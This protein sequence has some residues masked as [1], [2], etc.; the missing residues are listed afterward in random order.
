[1]VHKKQ[2]T[3]VLR[4]S[5]IIVTII[6]LV[7]IAV[8]VISL[9]RKD[10]DAFA[11][12]LAEKGLVMAGT[13]WCHYCA[14][15]KD[16]FKGAFEDVLIPTGAYKDCDQQKTWCEEA[17]VEGYPSWVLP[18]GNLLV[19]VQRLTTLATVSGCSL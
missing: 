9:P 7:V 5:I 1:M 4:K 17:G 6:F 13:S 11:S 10:Y 16:A 18:D 8:V 15:Q 2:G 3:R 19:G 12:C 14:A